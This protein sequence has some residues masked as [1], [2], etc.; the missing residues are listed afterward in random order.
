M[1][2]Q[3]VYP[4]TVDSSHS[5]RHQEYQVMGRYCGRLERKLK[6][7]ERRIIDLKRQ[8]DELEETMKEIRGLV[9]KPYIE[10]PYRR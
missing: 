6:G 9:S 3:G 7:K 8:V 4:E 10:R 2:E 5:T 1:K